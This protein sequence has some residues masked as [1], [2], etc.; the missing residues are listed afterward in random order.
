[1]DGNL[2][3]ERIPSYEGKY[4]KSRVLFCCSN[5]LTL[6]TLNRRRLPEDSM[7][8]RTYYPQIASPGGG[9]AV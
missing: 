4:D 7:W 2:L 8:A 9:L 1:M 6:R 3:K 5:K